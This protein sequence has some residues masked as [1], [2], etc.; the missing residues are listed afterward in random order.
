M[1]LCSVAFGCLMVC[2]TADAA[3]YI[4]ID[5][6]KRMTI[7]DDFKKAVIVGVEEKP[8][9]LKPYSTHDDQIDNQ[10]RPFMLQ[11][12]IDEDCDETAPGRCKNTGVAI[13]FYSDKRS[14][15]HIFGMD[16]KSG[17]IKWSYNVDAESITKD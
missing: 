3:Y 4:N 8:L 7:S 11:T 17:D 16:Q 10:G 14:G 13:K 1:K 2:F 9:R 6:N 15:M 12:F 5:T